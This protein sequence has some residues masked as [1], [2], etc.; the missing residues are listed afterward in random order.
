MLLEVDGEKEDIEQKHQKN[1]DHA[2]GHI[3]QRRNR[4]KQQAQ[5]CS[6]DYDYRLK[7]SN[8]IQ[9]DSSCI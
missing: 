5:Q 8:E 3:S 2:G 7:F 9:N 4:T 6:S 1:F